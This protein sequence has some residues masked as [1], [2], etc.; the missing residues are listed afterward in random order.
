MDVSKIE[1]IYESVLLVLE[2][3]TAAAKLTIKATI[4]ACLGGLDGGIIGWLA[5][6]AIGKVIDAVLDLEAKALSIALRCEY[7]YRFRKSTYENARRAWNLTNKCSKCRCIGHNKQNHSS[8]IDDFL[9]RNRLLS[10][11]KDAEELAGEV[12]VDASDLI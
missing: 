12:E 5:S 4:A 6:W 7:M 10:Y 11:V 1:E 3:G 2:A 8:D 9:M